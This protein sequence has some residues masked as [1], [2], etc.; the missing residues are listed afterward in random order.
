MDSE[1]SPTDLP[2]S[3]AVAML[4]GAKSDSW[5]RS[6]SGQLKEKVSKVQ[7]A[8]RSNRG[9]QESGSPTGKAVESAVPHRDRATMPEALVFL[10][11]CA[12][13]VSDLG[14]G[15]ERAGSSSEGK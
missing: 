10:G 7:S 5:V 1:D 13:S 2:R 11:E 4:K 6:V 15:R 9:N 3:A 12:A 14:D 8:H